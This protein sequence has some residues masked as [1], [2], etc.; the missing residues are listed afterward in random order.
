MP[1]TGGVPDGDSLDLYRVEC[2]SPEPRA[3]GTLLSRV[4]LRMVS[5]IA[6]DEY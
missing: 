3:Y 5:E 2:H 6:T 4:A 1:R